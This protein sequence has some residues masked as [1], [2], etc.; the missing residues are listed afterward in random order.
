MTEPSISFILGLKEI[1]L[2]KILMAVLT[3][4]LLGGC[5]TN[6]DWKKAQ[7][8]N[9]EKTVAK[10]VDYDSTSKKLIRSKVRDL[11][12]TTIEKFAG[13]KPGSFKPLFGPESYGY[14]VCYNVNTKNLLGIHT[15]NRL[16]MY[17]YDGET[18]QLEAIQ[19]GVD[20]LSDKRISETCSDII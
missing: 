12:G 10:P 3:L 18:A 17:I 6:H 19:S 15:G 2:M 9:I 13:P 1:D 11:K 5:A 16:Y 8:K 7:I 4:G 14:V 20:L